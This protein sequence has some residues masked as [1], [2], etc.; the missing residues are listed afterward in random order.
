[1]IRFQSR[2]ADAARHLPTVA[3][4]P[5]F[6]GCGLIVVLLA[7]SG[8]ASASATLSAAAVRK[9]ARAI[10]A[11]RSFA[12]SSAS[13]ALAPD[14]YPQKPTAGE[15]VHYLHLAVT[16]ARHTDAGLDALRGPANLDRA[17]KELVADN[18]KTVTVAEKMLARF[19][20]MPTGRNVPYSELD[21]YSKSLAARYG[22]A[23]LVMAEADLPELCVVEI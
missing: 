7:C 2:A 4:R 14:G 21:R 12:R 8:L 10:C 15:V 20:A 11:W 16:V 17:I 1:M 22:S 9:R 18:S 3:W 13:A 6:A 23:M 19:S 5:V